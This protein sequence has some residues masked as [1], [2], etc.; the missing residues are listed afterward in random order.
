M[1]IKELSQTT[2]VPTKTIRFYEDAGV[3][4]PSKRLP[5]GYRVYEARDADRLKLA[6]GMR[7]LDFSLDDIGEIIAMR[8]RREAPCRTVL[9][10]LQEKA[11]EIAARIQELQ[12]LES[13]LR[14]LH[15]L[16]LS[17]PTDDVDGK[18]CVCHLVSETY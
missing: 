12:K 10:R 11:D 7:R 9:D 4:P 17:F 13:D 5:N 14:A 8:D 15:D 2:G 3:L 6:A 16:G 18:N 1:Q